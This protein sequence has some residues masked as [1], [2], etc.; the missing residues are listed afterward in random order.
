MHGIIIILF[1]FGYFR[2]YVCCLTRYFG[3]FNAGTGPKPPS[4][5]GDRELSEGTKQAQSPYIH[6]LMLYSIYYIVNN[7]AITREIPTEVHEK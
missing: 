5:E 1:G 7:S 3:H 4:D 6:I 2:S